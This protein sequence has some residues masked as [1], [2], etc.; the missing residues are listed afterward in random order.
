MARAEALPSDSSRRAAG[1]ASAVVDAE[2]RERA[3]RIRVHAATEQLERAV[4]SPVSIYQDDDDCDCVAV[5]REDLEIVLA[6][7]RRGCARAEEA[8][9]ACADQAVRAGKAEAA[10]VRWRGRFL[11]LMWLAIVLAAGW[12]GWSVTWMAKEAGR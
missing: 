3:E 2:L 12:V 4:V 10:A 6:D 8:E 1:L 7:V 5:S 9:C 11:R